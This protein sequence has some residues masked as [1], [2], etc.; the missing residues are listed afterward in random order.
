MLRPVKRLLMLLA[1]AGCAKPS[2]VTETPSPAPSPSAS[3]ATPAAPE[4][5]P[6]PAVE[7][8]GPP[9]VAVEAAAPD[10][11]ALL[12]EKLLLD[13][14]GAPLPQTD[15]RPTT[16]SPAFQRRIELL[17]QAIATDDPKLAARVFFPVV[18]YRLVKDIAKPERDWQLRLMRAFDRNI[19]EYHQ[20]IGDGAT[21]VGLEVPEARAR[22]M[23]PGSEGNRL[24]YWRVLHSQL[25]VRTAKGHLRKLEVTSFISWRGEWYVVHLDGF[26]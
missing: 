21:F 6:A 25:S 23:K 4:P 12:D 22:F 1:V 20:K 10:P 9:D 15:D 5:P 18:A 14:G 13:P 8:A 7:D 24:G 2:P 17:F 19:H 26:K 3:V 11:D 16:T